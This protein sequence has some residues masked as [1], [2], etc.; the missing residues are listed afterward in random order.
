MADSGMVRPG[1]VVRALS[2]D[3]YAYE[4]MQEMAP[5]SKSYGHFISALILAEHARR[6]ERQ[7]YWRDDHP[8]STEGG[9][10]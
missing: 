7:H 8:I 5:T 4:L 6:Q 1:I 9:K 2:I 10:V 3:R